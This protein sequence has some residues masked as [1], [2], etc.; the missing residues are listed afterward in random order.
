MTE[1]GARDGRGF[2]ARRNRYV[3]RSHAYSSAMAGR[4]RRRGIFPYGR[5]R[6]LR[7]FWGVEQ[8]D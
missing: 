7:V 8:R 1:A 6:W 2:D 5:S 3:Y 4:E